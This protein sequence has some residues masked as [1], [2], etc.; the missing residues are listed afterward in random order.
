MEEEMAVIK[1]K[2]VNEYVD[3]TGKVRRYFRRG[4]IRGAL[5][6]NV[7]SEEFMAAYEAFLAGRAVEA[8]TQ[9][10]GEGTFGRLIS[11]YYTS[12]PYLNLKQSSRKT[13]R[14]VLEPLR[15]KHGHRLVRDMP[16]DKVVKILE[17]IGAT[18]PAM[19]NLTRRVLAELMRYAVKQ[20]WRADNPVIGLEPYKTGT[21][22]TWNEAELRAFEQRWPLGTRERLAYALLLYTCQRVGDVARMKRSDIVD[23]EIH[24]IQEKTGAELYLPV[25]PELR[26]AMK[27]YPAK[28]LTLIGWKDGRPISTNGLSVIIR[29]AVK[30]ASLPAKCVAHGLRKASMRRLA[31]LGATEKQIAAWS[32]HK[33]LNEVVRYTAAA[34]QKRLARDAMSTKTRTGLPNSK[35]KSD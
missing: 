18:K 2:Y 20:K 33:T 25:L 30:K 32:G 5:P 27:A 14:Y 13:Y 11:E 10:S 23:G 8:K 7:G 12:R 24:V 16:A 35:Q 21:H 4:A 22:H 9:R 29:H 15:R 3:R 17:E 19:A 6:G 34:D 28:G 26:Q 31:E 1:L